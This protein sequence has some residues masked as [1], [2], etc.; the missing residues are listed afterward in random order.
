MVTKIQNDINGWLVVDKPLNMG[1]TQVVSVLKRLLHPMKI[2]HGGTL[3]PLASGVL[4]IALGKATRTV[5]FVMDGLKRYEFCI[6]F[7][8]TTATD[9]L[10]GE[11]LETTSKI[12]SVDEI[13][14]VL[15]KFIGDIEQMPPAY[16]ALKVGGKRAYDLAREGKQ[17]ELKFRIIHIEHLNFIEPKENG[18]MLFEVVCGKGTYV[19]SLGRDIAKACGSLGHLS[20]LRRT[21]CGAFDIKDS[22]SL[23][24]I[25]EMCYNN[26]LIEQLF[27]IETVLSDILEL[28]LTEE[29]AKALCFGQAL[30]NRWDLKQNEQYKAMFQEKLVAFVVVEGTKVRP[31][32]VFKQLNEKEN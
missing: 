30:K 31:T 20:Y 11:V 15:L 18:D 21:A 28:A 16:S 27:S 13:K 3:D 8:A 4:P 1:S 5:P 6:R 22:F 9:D 17:P 32:K 24:K 19:R 14:S 7:G 26:T 25:K 12:P 23:E 29:E 10:E 2:G